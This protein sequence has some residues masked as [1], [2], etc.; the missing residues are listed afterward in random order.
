MLIVRY[1]V[2]LTDEHYYYYYFFTLGTYDP[3]GRFKKIT[4]KIRK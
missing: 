1:V 2:N 3:E 4:G